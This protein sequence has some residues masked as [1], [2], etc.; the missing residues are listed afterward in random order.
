MFKRFVGLGALYSLAVVSL[1]AAPG[2]ARADRIQDCVQ[3]ADLDLQVR[4]C[5]EIIASDGQAAWA[6][7]NRSWAHMDKGLHDNAVADATKAI[8][9]NP[10]LALGYV[11]RA[12]ALLN[13]G[14]NDRA[15]ADASRAIAIDAKMALA[16]V[17]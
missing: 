4:A 12:G 15:I 13:K 8:E 2:T 17:N 3:H 16:Y 5:T 9:I 11:N 14:E 7:V 6:Y 1:I 10:Q